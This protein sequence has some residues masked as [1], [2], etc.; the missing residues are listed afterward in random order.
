MS[1][2]ESRLQRRPRPCSHTKTG[3]AHHGRE[4]LDSNG[5]SRWEDSRAELD[6]WFYAHDVAPTP[7][8]GVIVVGRRKQAADSDLGRLYVARYSSTG[9][10]VWEQALASPFL[11]G[12][13]ASG[14]AVAVDAAGGV[15][16]VGSV[17]TDHGRDI[18]ILKLAA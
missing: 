8:D 14:N 17:E 2:F 15:V 6:G 11:A 12:G 9:T 18:W 3:A 5:G 16:V 10:L 13:T 7:E 1:G 4:G